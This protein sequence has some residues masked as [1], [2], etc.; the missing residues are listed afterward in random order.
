MPLLNIEVVFATQSQYQIISLQVNEGTTIEQAIVQSG[1]LSLFPEIDL[2]QNQVGIF[3][4]I[5]TL[6]AVVEQGD[7]VEIYR[8]LRMSA[9]A[10]RTVRA[11]KQKKLNPRS[12]VKDRE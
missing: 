12:V 9:M 10:A 8:P 1:I 4:E 7:R 6:D 3:N 5:K 2:K 11:S